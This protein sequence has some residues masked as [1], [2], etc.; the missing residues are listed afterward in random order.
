MGLPVFFGDVSP[1]G[2]ITVEIPKL[3]EPAARFWERIGGSEILGA[4]ESGEPP[5]DNRPPVGTIR[6]MEG[7][8]DGHGGWC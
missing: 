6:T 3:G 4:P 1:I 2:H 5:G 8:Q 7:K